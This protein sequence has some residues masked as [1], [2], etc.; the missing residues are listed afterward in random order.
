MKYK[1]HHVLL[2]AML[3]LGWH[4]FRYQDYPAGKG[5]WITFIKVA[6]LALMVYITNYFL[7]PRFLYR[8]KYFTFGLLFISIVFIFSILKMYVEVALLKWASFNIWDR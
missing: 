8:K 7:I 4:F 2:W 1:L 6:D 5:W 3:F